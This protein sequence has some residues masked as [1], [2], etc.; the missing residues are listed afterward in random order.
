MF[1]LDAFSSK[2]QD[3]IV[4]TS[5]LEKVKLYLLDEDPTDT[6]IIDEL[7]RLDLGK[8]H[9]YTRF[10]KSGSDVCIQHLI[11]ESQYHL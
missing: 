6:L 10:C 3:S 9:S 1:V 5:I 7:L 2:A 8:V 11:I 4:K